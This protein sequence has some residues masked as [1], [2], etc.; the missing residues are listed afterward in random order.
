MTAKQ[1]QTRGCHLGCKQVLCRFI[2]W[3]MSLITTPVGSMR[4]LKRTSTKSLPASMYRTRLLD[5]C[6]RSWTR[7][8]FADSVNS[9]SGF[10]L[11]PNYLSSGLTDDTHTPCWSSVTHESIVF[12]GHVRDKLSK[13]TDH[14]RAPNSTVANIASAYCDVSAD[15]KRQVSADSRFM[16]ESALMAWIELAAVN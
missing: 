15:D 9:T 16:R 2:P 7:T 8:K 3:D 13:Q 4:K 1:I 10:M 14:S 12:Q 11:D 6:T 5:F